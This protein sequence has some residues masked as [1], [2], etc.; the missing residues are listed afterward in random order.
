MLVRYSKNLNDVTSFT[1]LHE[2]RGFL[3][4]NGFH[5]EKT[6]IWYNSWVYI[7]TYIHIHTNSKREA[8]QIDIQDFHLQH[9]DYSRFFF[10][11]FF[12]FNLYF[13]FFGKYI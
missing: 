11:F 7:Y 6:K 9:K 10:F 2:L 5:S 8:T 13:F 3:S 4:T 12:F 1:P